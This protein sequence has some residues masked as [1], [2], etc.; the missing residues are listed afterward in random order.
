MRSSEG[1]LAHGAELFFRACLLACRRVCAA[2]TL[3]Q[4]FRDSTLG[5]R[6]EWQRM[7]RPCWLRMRVRA[8]W[9]VARRAHS[10][11]VARVLARGLLRALARASERV[12][13]PGG[14]GFM[15]VRD[16]FDRARAKQQRL[17]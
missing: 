2:G 1:G 14:I 5:G 3:A 13:A 4:P 12:Y 8:L 6:G 9:S 16:E 11:Y 17:I 7:C 15:H 10:S